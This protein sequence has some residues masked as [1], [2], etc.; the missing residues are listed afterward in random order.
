[1]KSRESEGYTLKICPQPNW[2]T[3]KK[4][5]NF[6]IYILPFEPKS[7]LDKQLSQN[8]NPQ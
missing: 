2:K 8:Y 5:I 6:L 7:R 4:W 1:M 3:K